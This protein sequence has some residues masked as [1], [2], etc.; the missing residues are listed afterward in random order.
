M[1]NVVRVEIILRY[2]NAS[3]AWPHEYVVIEYDKY[4]CIITQ[5]SYQMSDLFCMLD[6]AWERQLTN[7]YR[8]IDTTVKIEKLVVTVSK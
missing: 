4:N 2:S 7:K 1:E 6:R 5:M 8:I 3:P